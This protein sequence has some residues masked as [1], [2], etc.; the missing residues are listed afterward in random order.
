M[1]ISTSC[2]GHEPIP[3]SITEPGGRELPAGG[4]GDVPTPTAEGCMDQ[5]GIMHG[6]SCFPEENLMWPWSRGRAADGQGCV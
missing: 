3:E 5:H 2:L 4:P 1:D 6:E